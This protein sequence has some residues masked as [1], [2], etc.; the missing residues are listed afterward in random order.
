M[1]GAA[2]P[3]LLPVQGVAR[4]V[5]RGTANGQSCVNV[6]HV[7]NGVSAHTA[8]SI[9][10]LAVQIAAL[11]GTHFRPL[12][13]NVWSGDEVTCTDLTSQFG[14]TG[15]ASLPGAGAVTGSTVPQSVACCISWR[16]GRHYRGG[17]PRTYLGPPGS[18][19]LE[20]NVSFTSTYVSSVSAA[21][22]NFRSGV[23][24]LVIDGQAQTLVSVHRTQN[25][26]Q[27]NPP[28]TSNITAGV[29]DSRIDTMRRRLGPDR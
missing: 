26:A 24:T 8:S 16:I 7:R 19:A 23:N 9:Q 29:V 6:F 10:S 18:A 21:A 27:L 5:V 12:L 20:N 11:Y 22:G 28:Q 15:V 25:L 4:C 3:A 2:M 1:Y 17:H 13:N 14:E